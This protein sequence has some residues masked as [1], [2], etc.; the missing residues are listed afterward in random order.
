MDH[1]RDSCRVEWADSHEKTA[2]IAFSLWKITFKSKL[3]KR[4]ESIEYERRLILRAGFEV[5]ENSWT[6]NLL[7]YRL[8]IPKKTYRIARIYM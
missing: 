4:A 5:I 1:T 8:L 6:G 2:L 7:S 3:R